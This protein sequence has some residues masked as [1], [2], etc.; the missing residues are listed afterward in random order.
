MSSFDDLRKAVVEGIEGKNSGPSMGFDRLN[1]FIGIRKRIYTV[2]FGPTGSGKSAFVDSA[3]ILNPFDWMISKKNT[4]GIKMKWILFSQERSKIYKLAKWVARKI[5]LEQGVLIPI[6]RLLGWWEKKISNQ[7]FQ[8][9]EMYEPYIDLLLEH[10]DIVEGPQNPTGMYKYI[11]KYAEEHGTFDETDKYHPKY[12]PNDPLEIVIPIVDHFGL[13]KKERGME[14]KE[15]IDKVSEDFQKFRDL[16][17][18]SPLGVSQLTRNLNNPLYSKMDSFAP[19]LDDIKESGRPGEDA[20]NVL[21]VFEPLRY[22]TKDGSYDAEAFVNPETGARNFRSISIL[23]N[24]YGESDIN[25]GM[26]F[27]GAT[28]IFKELP[29]PSN[30]NFFSY[31]GVIDGSYFLL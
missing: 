25:I 17:G 28:G 11:H 6:P 2:V 1:R 30:M 21:S 24:S 20:D 27:E 29:K 23:K 13:T 7:D 10:V 31:E 9:F 5:F 26:A 19:S 16:C 22:R 8:Y 14:K 3:Y 18:Y 12:I 15:A 4:L